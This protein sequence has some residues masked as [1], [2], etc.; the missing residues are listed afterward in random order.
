MR[1]PRRSGYS[2]ESWG[3]PEGNLLNPSRYQVVQEHKPRPTYI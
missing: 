2:H 1:S 3:I